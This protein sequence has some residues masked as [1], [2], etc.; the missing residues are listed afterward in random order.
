MRSF[1]W[2]GLYMRTIGAKVAWDQ[3]CLLKKEGG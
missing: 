2:L 3:V 1:P